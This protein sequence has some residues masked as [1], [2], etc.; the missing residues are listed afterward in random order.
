MTV[1][2]CNQLGILLSTFMGKT[3]ES[4]LGTILFLFSAL[5]LTAVVLRIVVP[6]V[7]VSPKTTPYAPT[8]IEFIFST[9]YDLK[10]IAREAYGYH[11]FR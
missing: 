11:S 1:K 10:R 8:I 7:A 5:N 6:A 3:C 2:F 9:P 4:V